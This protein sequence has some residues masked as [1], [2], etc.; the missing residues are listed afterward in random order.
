M[1]DSTQRR[2]RKCLLNAVLT[3]VNRDFTGLGL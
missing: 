2:P 3:W 1:G